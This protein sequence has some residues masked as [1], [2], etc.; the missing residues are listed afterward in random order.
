[1]MAHAAWLPSCLAW[2]APL[3]YNQLRQ[4]L[5]ASLSS[6]ERRNVAQDLNGQNEEIQ[7]TPEF[8]SYHLSK[9]QEELDK[10]QNYSADCNSSSSSCNMN[11]HCEAYELALFVN[12][13]YVSDSAFRLQ[14]LRADKFDSRVSAQ[15]FIQYWD[16][17]VELFGVD[18]AFRKLSIHDLCPEDNAALMLGGL[19][20]FPILDETGR[21]FFSFRRYWDNRPSHKESMLRLLW[22]MAHTAL[23]DP[24]DGDTFQKKGFVLIG[25]SGLP[26]S[27]YFSIVSSGN[28]NGNINAC[29]NG[30]GQ[31]EQ[32]RRQTN[33][34]P[35]G[36]TIDVGAAM[37]YDVQYALPMRL[38]A[39]HHFLDS[40]NRFHEFLSDHLL[41]LLNHDLRARYRRYVGG[42]TQENLD[43][44][45]EHGIYPDMVPL[46]LGGEF[47]FNYSAWLQRKREEDNLFTQQCFCEQQQ[48]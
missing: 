42:T 10:L 39:F 11:I 9:F 2:E 23:E 19:R 1:M 12:P 46:E 5:R 13:A 14:F 30:I 43:K 18:K 37:L 28:N 45:A 36:T 38:V 31:Q 4:E 48:K 27:A 25:G 47:D 6:E 32:R 24:I 41:R 33:Q 20:W 34:P 15:R 44:L 17:K 8:I 40:S 7:E 21:I 3:S 22:W 29:C 35:I 26:D 16:R